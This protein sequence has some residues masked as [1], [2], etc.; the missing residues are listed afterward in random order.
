MDQA[1]VDIYILLTKQKRN[2]YRGTGQRCDDIDGQHRLAACQLRK[3]VTQEQQQRT[4]KTA[5]GHEDKVTGSAKE[6]TGDMRYCY[7]YK[8][9]RPAESR[10]AACQQSAAADA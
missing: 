10:D 9:Y 7:A 6:L 2:D 4:D 1:L 3:H 5:G 8:S